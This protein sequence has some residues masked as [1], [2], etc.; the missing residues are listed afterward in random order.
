VRSHLPH[1]RRRSVLLTAAA[2]V[3]AVAGIGAVALGLRDSG[4]TPTPPP[5]KP[6]A[7][8]PSTSAE[9]P[10][11]SAGGGKTSPRESAIEQL[12]LSYSPPVR[13]RVPTIGVSSSLVT[14]GLDDDG[15]M[16]TPEPVDR[17]GW[18]EPSPPPG[19]PGATVIAGH[20][21]WDREPSVFFRL[22]DLSP[23]DRIAVTRKDGARVTYTVTR[24]GSFPKDGFP[25]R[26]V[27]DQ[28]SRSELRLIT[29]GGEY[30][31]AASRYLDNVIVW[32]K[33]SGV[34]T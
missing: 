9:D 1:A 24:I 3:L 32:A 15:V 16:E 13:L 6:A 21:T 26:A 2:I 25:T 4:S 17:A 27:Y 33:I 22:G 10:G 30:D 7:G 19:I 18:F 29:C 8:S 31:E 11:P 14:L 34:R 28:P 12:E 20:V 5:A 23:G